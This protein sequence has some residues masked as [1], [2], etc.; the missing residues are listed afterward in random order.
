M[1]FKISQKGNATV[2]AL[3]GNLLGV[4]EA[5][6]LNGQVHKLLEDGKKRVVLDLSEVG[7]INSSGLSGLIHSA[8]TLNK[9]GGRL[10]VAGA[11]KKVLELIKVTRLTPVIEALPDV[12]AALE[13]LSE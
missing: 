1:N 12:N 8:S 4:P 11:S 2:I 13:A 3:Q 9:T 7:F 10:V 5:A 6:E